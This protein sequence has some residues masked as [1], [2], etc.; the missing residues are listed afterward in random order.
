M[1]HPIYT[2]C[3]LLFCILYLLL[4]GIFNYLFVYIEQTQLFQFTTQYAYSVLFHPGGLALYLSEFLV[5]FYILPGVGAFITT[6]LL[7][8]ITAST[9][10]LLKQLRPQSKLFLLYVLP[11]LAL[12]VLHLDYNYYVQGS[13]A[14]LLMLI[15]LCIYL[16]LKFPVR[17]IVGIITIPVLFLLAGSVATLYTISIILVD[18]FTHEKRKILSLFYFPDLLVTGLC[19]IYWGGI[20]ETRII[21]M[22][23]MYY[24][25]A[26]ETSKV[27]YIWIV[28]LFCL[29]L[30]FTIKRQERTLPTLKKQIILQGIQWLILIVVGYHLINAYGDIKG[31]KQKELDY[32]V[33][34][35]QWEKVINLF[36]CEVLSLQRM[37]ML[38]LALAETGQLST[39]LTDYPQNSINTLI[40]PWNRNVYTASLHSDIY[41]SMGII[42]AAQ[43]FAFEAYISSHTSGNPRMLKRLIEINIIT[44]AYP[45]AEKYIRILENTWYYKEWA[46]SYRSFLYNDQKVKKDK[47]LGAKRHCWQAEQMISDDYTDPVKIL[48]KLLLA[49]PKNETG[50][51]YLTS[52]V[53]LSKDIDM[54]RKLL[55]TFYRT[56]AWPSLS[57]CQQ[58]AVV[59]CN[60]NDPHY[61]LEH[62]VSLKVRNRSVTYMDKVQANSRMSNLPA[63]MAPE[64]G[65]TYWYYYMFSNE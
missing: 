38:N 39:R 33:R 59:I 11:S 28:F 19:G 17:F 64:Y 7:V 32:Y 49:Y 35:S 58:E 50:M 57:V 56:S 6:L 3:F 10:Y 62:G 54:Y 30:T 61:W 21:F 8:G 55:D 60:P 44:G 25:P 40:I 34:M 53:L 5:Q 13:L 4:Y 42:A 36:D 48:V 1:K 18:F 22:P 41:Y 26:V 24:D 51:A 27:W 63:V 47:I 16:K 23:D 37:N 2:T 14:Y 45:V 46:S 52:F 31:L 20:S 12:L 15:F 29:L 43:K 65:K 9:A